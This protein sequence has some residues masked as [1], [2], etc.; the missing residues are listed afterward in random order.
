M[1]KAFDVE[2]NS[3]LPGS[4][5]DPPEEP[6]GL[7]EPHR[8]K[9]EEVH[10][11]AKKAP[12]GLS[13]YIA[14]LHHRVLPGKYSRGKL[15]VLI[16]LAKDKREEIRHY[17]LRHP[18]VCRKVDPHPNIPT[19]YDVIPLKN[20]TGWWVLDQ[21]IEGKSL[22]DL[23]VEQSGTPI[24]EKSL[25]TLGENILAGLSA[26]HEA[27]VVFRE[28]APDKVWIGT[29][30]SRIQL[31]DFELAKFMEGA[32][33][34][35]G[36]WESGYFRAPE[37]NDYEAHPQSDLYSFAKLVVWTLQG[38]NKTDDATSAVASLPSGVASS[39]KA[40]LNVQIS[41]R[42]QTRMRF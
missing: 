29:D 16:N 17:L 8:W 9:I 22:E 23:C 20:D 41:G 26:L 3:F 34:V 39:L 42:P 19:N 32:P 10:G 14:T 24:D 11:P 36:E 40:C 28:L 25:R 4:D 12:N 1:C 21:W 5:F 15:Y 33:S 37:V 31:T 13:Y 30:W 35:S 6:F 2:L 18:E 38:G 27:G 7:T